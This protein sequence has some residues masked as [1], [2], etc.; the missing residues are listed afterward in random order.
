MIVMVRYIWFL[1]ELRFRLE[2]RFGYEV[3]DWIMWAICMV[4]F[5]LMFWLVVFTVAWI[6]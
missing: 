2:A 5:I 6:I 4:H 3:A 1:E